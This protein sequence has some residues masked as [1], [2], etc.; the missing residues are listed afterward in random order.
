MQVDKASVIQPETILDFID[1]TTQRKD[2]PEERVRQEILKSLV[3]EYGYKKDQIEVE[4][5]IKFGSNRKAVD[6]A[7]WKPGQAHTQE[8]IYIIVECKDPKTKSRGKKDGVD[9]MH[10]YASACM[11]STY[12]MWTNGDELLTFRY[13]VDKTGKRV[14]DPVPD[15]PHAG[16][17]VPDDAPKFDQLRP[18]A[19]D[20]LLYSFRR[21]HN[22]IAGNQGIQKAEAFLELLKII[23]C[24]IQDERDS[25]TPT[26]YITPTERQG[27][28]GKKKCRKRI[29]KLFGS[30]KQSY[31]TIFKG[32]EQIGLTDDVLAY[33]VAQ[34]QMYSLLESDVD[35][36]GHAYETI[37]GSNLRGDK[38][39]FFTPRNMC[40]MMVRMV[41]PNEEDVILDPA[42]GTCGFLVTGMNY[43]LEKIS[44]S[45]ESSGRSKTAKKEALTRRK[46]DF[47]TRHIVG[48]D[49]DP[50]LVRA[51]KMNMVMNND[52][53]G[54]LF[55]ANSL[56]PF[57]AFSPDLLK[58]LRLDEKDV[59]ENKATQEGHGVTAIVTNPPF[60]SKIPVDD[61]A[62]L[63]AYD[64]GHSWRYD[65]DEMEWIMEDKLVSRPPEILFIERCVKLLEP[66][67][68]VVAIVIPNGIL[69]NP[70][71]G[72]VRQWLFRHTWIIASIDM[73]PDTFQPNVGV[74]TSVLMVRRLDA[75]EEAWFRSGSI[76]DYKIFMAICD[77]V[78]HDKRGITTYVR[79]EDGYPIVRDQTTA[80]TGLVASDEENAH[81][82]K[83]RVIDDDTMAIA[84]A[85]L[86]WRRDQ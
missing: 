53:T 14:P 13:V 50:I 40:R 33:I 1:G 42:M 58:A 44:E 77:H 15:L 78:G 68:G 28:N 47:L 41:D 86:E 63:G 18:A 54:Q 16:G 6:V 67:K 38:G 7:I 31:E 84:D 29:E 60:G 64:F 35:V 39:Q 34:L 56:E 85:F 74:Q 46:Q 20:S 2:T 24:K 57:S 59:K 11:N 61:P 62:I 26:F 52:G 82:S 27:A 83:E 76:L 22:Y 8:G 9:Q 80:V 32:D 66:G 21:C 72:F 19:S 73:H 49:F 45:V 4:Y 51:S 65:E 75:D 71:L 69:G 79:D 10:S 25:P 17:E 36:K 30:V 70:G 81:S 43:V 12:G 3:R 5:S 55:H 48:I 37:V 23:F